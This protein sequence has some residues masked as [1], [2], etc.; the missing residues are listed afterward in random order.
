LLAIRASHERHGHVQEVIV[1]NFR[2]KPD[3]LMAEHPE[4]SVDDM[5]LTVALARLILG[6][7]VS[8]Q[9]PPNLTP[10]EYGT[11]LGAGLSDW[12]GVSP[13]TPDHVN[14]ERPWPHLDELREGTTARGFLLLARLAVYPDY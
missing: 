6:P 4:P 2:G 7:Q 3:T 8:V 13:V 1:Q 12:G 10:G 11:Y 14:P 5:S 9:A